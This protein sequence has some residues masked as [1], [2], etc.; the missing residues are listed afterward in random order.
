MKKLISLLCVFVL[1]L[2]LA[3]PACGDYELDPRAELVDGVIRLTSRPELYI[4]DGEYEKSR[5]YFR[6][7]GHLGEIEYGPVTLEPVKVIISDYTL[8]KP[9]TF[10]EYVLSL[11]K[12]YASVVIQI[13]VRNNGSEPV[14]YSPMGALLS[15]N[16]SDPLL[17]AEFFTVDFGKAVKVEP[18]K[19]SVLSVTFFSEDLSAREIA[20]LTLSLPPFVGAD[21]TPL[22][23]LDPLRFELVKPA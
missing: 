15:A 17:P 7:I 3:A 16:A 5:D 11:N 14:W 6:L 20:S 8:K 22:P 1:L 18:G 21:L 13:K 19:T 2:A 9:I 4:T 10:H 12:L 23:D